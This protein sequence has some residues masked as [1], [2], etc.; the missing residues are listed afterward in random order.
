VSIDDHLPP[1]TEDPA[2]ESDDLES[3][4]FVPRHRDQERRRRG[5]R[6]RAPF[7]RDSVEKPETPV[8]SE[9]EEATDKE[10]AYPMTYRPA[11]YEGVWLTA[12][13]RSFFEQE[14]IVDVLA[15]VKGG[16]EASVYR[17]RAH[18]RLG[19]DLLAA[20][21]YRPRKFR[22]LRNDSLYR[23]GR[24]ILTAGGGAV[25]KRDRR[26]MLAVRK[27]TDFGARLQH[28]SWLMHEYTTLDRLYRQ[29]A[30]VP[31][32]YAANENAILMTYY[33]DELG[34][35]PT[36]NETSLSRD[37]A[38]TIWPEV[39]RNLEVMLSVGLIHGDLSA[40]N[41]LYWEGRITL[42]DFPQGTS[43]QG[44]QSAAF[45][46]RRDVQRVAEYFARRGIPVDP[47]QVYADLAERYDIGQ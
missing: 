37:E 38:R 14:L 8:G 17:C 27:K 19:V 32:P 13:L 10:G 46:L 30:A 31:R 43:S 4:F 18:P 6:P 21:V 7:F 24:P 12:S 47:S 39:R 11:R 3:W 41:L 20:K 44:N 23:E 36:L 42:I 35:A 22:N 25:S 33:G 29:G 26:T 5:A 40:Y 34:A 16:K 9:V 28:T 45:I 15:Q 2:S 1:G